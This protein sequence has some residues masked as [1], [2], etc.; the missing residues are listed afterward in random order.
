MLLSRA[1]RERRGAPSDPEVERA[2]TVRPGREPGRA[3]FARAVG[4]GQ[5]L[6]R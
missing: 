4:T 5:R 3:V 2:I 6:K 1:A